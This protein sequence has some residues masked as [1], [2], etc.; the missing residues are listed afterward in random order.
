[1]VIV[2][3]E[4]GEIYEAMKSIDFSKENG[5]FK[6]GNINIPYRCTCGIC[7]TTYN[8]EL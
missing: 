2:Y 5:V 4:M 7:D 8:A 3:K 6:T 1:M